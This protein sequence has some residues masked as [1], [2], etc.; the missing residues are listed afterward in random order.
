MIN[1]LIEHLVNHK[2]SRPIQVLLNKIF[3]ALFR[4]N[5]DEHKESSEYN[6][7]QELFTR[8][9]K[10]GIRKFSKSA[11]EIISPVD[12]TLI[13]NG[14]I[15][16]GTLFQIKGKSYSLNK[17]L[18]GVAD[19]Q[20]LEHADYFNFY[21]SPKDYHHYHSPCDLEILRAVF[22]P[23][24]L[25]P[26]SYFFQKFRKNLFAEN[27]RVILEC[28]ITD[29]ITDNIM[30]NK[31][32]HDVKISNPEMTDKLIYVICI[33]ALNVGRICFNFDSRIENL[34]TFTVL[35]YDTP[36]NVAKGEDLGCF[37]LG[38][39]LVL[40]FQ[41]KFM[42]PCESLNIMSHRHIKFGQIIGHKVL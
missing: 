36:I 17:L 9:L 41:D 42:H 38:S 5:L 16:A 3:T 2:F 21:L 23:G 28:R 13:L 34:K 20:K 15:N 7:I 8:E 27:K 6:S 18:S 24:R 39:S 22:V 25:F 30:T 26:V 40:I 11:H 33:G 31:R 14:K 1:I 10:Q 4:M 29:K 37:K 19:L 35:N 32:M 12:G